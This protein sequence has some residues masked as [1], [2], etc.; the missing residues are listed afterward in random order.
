MTTTDRPPDRHRQA[1]GLRVPRRRRGRA[2]PS[3]ARSCAMGDRLGY[4]RDLADHGPTT[5]AELADR[6]ETGA[7]YARE[8][9]NAQA[10][11]S[12]VEL[13]RREPVATRC[14][15][16]TPW[17][18][19]TRPVR[20]TCPASSRSRSAPCATSTV[21]I[22]AARSRR[23]GGLARAQHATCTIGCERFFRPGYAANLVAD[24]AAALDGV[25]DEARGR[26]PGR[27]RRL[28]PRLRRRC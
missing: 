4:Y 7:H 21:V 3:A 18:S 19:P 24:L 6:T 12:V 9:L 5:A 2:P 10:A 22:E 25:V 26:R 14:R 23:R 15:R 27:R 13:R 17:R 1:D 28:R 20:R 11:G 16:S 8:W